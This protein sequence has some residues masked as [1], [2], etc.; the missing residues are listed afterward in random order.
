MQQLKVS[1]QDWQCAKCKAKEP[2]KK[3][4]AEIGD[5]YK[6]TIHVECVSCGD[7]TRIERQYTRQE[8]DKIGATCK[9]IETRMKSG[10]V[11]IKKMPPTINADEIRP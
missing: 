8:L 10:L 2:L 7:K 6:L 1:I 5:D 3:A 9:L 4:P 11:Q